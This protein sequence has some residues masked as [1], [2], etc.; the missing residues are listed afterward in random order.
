MQSGF[1]DGAPCFNCG[2]LWGDGAICQYCHQVYGLAAGL[3]VATPGRRC[4]AYLLEVTLAIATCGIGHLIWSL[5]TFGDGQSPAKKLLGLRVVNLATSARATWGTMFLREILAKMLIGALLGWAVIPY[6]WLLID[7]NKQQLWDKLLDTMVVE[8]PNGLVEAAP[9]AVQT[10]AQ[11]QLPPPEQ[12]V[13]YSQGQGGYSQG[14]DSYGRQQ[15]QGGPY[16]PR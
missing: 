6:F 3:T 11:Q 14:Q 15:P 12:Q 5:F 9:R 1:A 4:L 10:Y 7:K 8:D 2:R 13:P 16:P